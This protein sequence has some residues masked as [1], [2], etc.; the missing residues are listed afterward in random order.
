M[1]KILL[2]TIGACSLLLGV[3]GLFLPLLPTTPF[4][5]LAAWCFVKSSHR[6]HSWLYRQPLLGP[7]LRD[8]DQDRAIS[9]RTK[10]L[11]IAM[12][13]AS[14]ALLWIRV[15]VLWIQIPITVILVGVALFIATRA[16]TKR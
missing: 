1:A 4:L 10:I 12:I 2:F 9:K 15:P 13:G 3:I 16:E 11:A 5:L 7:V 8:W 6:A 14:I